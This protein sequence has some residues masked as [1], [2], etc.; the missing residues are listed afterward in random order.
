[1]HRLPDAVARPVLERAKA[2]L[3]TLDL[4]PSPVRIDRVRLVVFPFYFRLP[5]FRRFKGYTLWRTILLKFPPG[6]GTS[7]DLMTH[8]LCHIWQGQQ[9]RWKTLWTYLTTRYDRNPYEIEA[10]AAAVRTRPE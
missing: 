5:P 1:M 2:R 10:R 7:N 6:A 3:D 4:Y 8:E 9:Q